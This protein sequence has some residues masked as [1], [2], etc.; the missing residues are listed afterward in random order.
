MCI[1]DRSLEHRL[2]NKADSS[3]QWIRDN[4]MICAGDKTKL[5]VVGTKQMRDSKLVNNNKTLTVNV[6]GQQVQES[7]CE[8]LLGVYMENDLTWNVYL[9]GNDKTGSEKITGLLTKL[10]Q[11]VGILS[12]LAKVLTFK[13]FKAVSNGIFTSK[14][15]YCLP[16]FCNTWD[17]QMNE[18]NDQI[19]YLFSK[20]DLNKL[21]IL[22]NK[23]LRMR[24]RQKKYTPVA[25]LLKLCN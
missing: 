21:Q 24:C 11:R 25:T 12:K 7:S 17:K 23:V 5:M 8:K 20:N 6:C 22:Q 13:Q 3:S 10:S 4:E 15:L 19:C 14:L 1:R 18:S 9:H 2:Q 16:L